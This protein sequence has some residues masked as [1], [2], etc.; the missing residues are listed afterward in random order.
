MGDNLPNSTHI[1][2][3]VYSTSLYNWQT[4][5]IVIGELLYH[6]FGSCN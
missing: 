2:H 1:Y 3:P 6:H 5:D 4:F